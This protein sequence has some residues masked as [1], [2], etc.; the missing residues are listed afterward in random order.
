MIFDYAVIGKGL[1]GAAAARYLS[2]MHGR[3]AIVGPDEPATSAA[4]AAATVFASHYDEG[5][6][7]GLFGRGIV[8]SRLAHHALQGHPALEAAS[9]IRFHAP[10]GRLRALHHP[11][12]PAFL[13]AVAAELDGRYER[14][15]P[16]QLAQR[17]PYLR[18][19]AA[20]E[21][22]YEPP[23]AGHINP[24]AL[25]R[26][27]LAVA[28]QNGAQ[29]VREVVTA[30]AL[31]PD[32]ATIVLQ[33]GATLQARKV[34]LATGAFTNAL[35]LL[36]R[37]L[38]L[39]IKSETIILA[40]VSQVDAA[41]LGAMP[42]VD[43]DLSTPELDDIYLTP[44]LRYPDGRT[45]LKM[46]CNT[47]VDHWF[48]GLD[49]MQAWFRSG[50]SDRVRAAMTEALRSFMPDVTPQ[51]VQTRRCIVTYTRHGHPYIGPVAGDR[52]CVAVGGNGTGA[53]ASD[54][55]GYLAAHYLHNGR[56]PA[57][58]DAATFVPVWAAA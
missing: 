46:G 6:L 24:R 23:P 34:L 3:V 22:L 32:A 56:F 50:D 15:T 49:A 9:G 14:W 4:T 31:A 52:I 26:A 17:H 18:F 58:F 29:I 37:R 47:A 28:Q 55:V 35:T 45:Y 11:K 19:P 43:Y 53:H 57:G 12:D 51:S 41:R 38:D 2:A 8:W 16:A 42:A 1:F 5:R 7:T 13:E 48:D 33:S 20:C 25:I 54:G 39:R 21:L 10:V 30:L 40:E 36:P 44:P 27:Q